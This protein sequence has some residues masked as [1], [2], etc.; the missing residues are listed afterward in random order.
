MARFKKWQQRGS[1][2]L[3]SIAVGMVIL[4]IAATGTAASMIYGR[5]IMGRQERYK[6]AAYLLRQEMEKKMWEL[7]SFARAQQLP[8]LQS[9]VLHTQLVRSNE[10]PER[11]QPVE[12]VIFMDRIIAVPDQEFLVLLLFAGNPLD[13]FAHGQVGDLAVNCH[14]KGVSVLFALDRRVNEGQQS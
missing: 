12:I 11:N 2:D 5:E 1:A 3:V 8:A 9:T 6:Q 7:Q 4:S 14:V 13:G 10:R